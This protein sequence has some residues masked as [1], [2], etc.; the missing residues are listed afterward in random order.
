LVLDFAIAHIIDNR[1]ST[2]GMITRRARMIELVHMGL[3]TIV[4]LCGIRALGTVILNRFRVGLE[5]RAQHRQVNTGILA[6]RT[7]IRLGTHMVSKVVL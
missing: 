5:M 1:R 6:L 7:L 2:H 4:V 3:Q